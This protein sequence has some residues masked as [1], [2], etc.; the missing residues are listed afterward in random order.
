VPEKTFSRIPSKEEVQEVIESCLLQGKLNE[1]TTYL[2]TTVAN[3]V[4]GGKFDF[5]PSPTNVLQEFYTRQ[6]LIF[7]FFQLIDRY[8]QVTRTQAEIE[9]TIFLSGSSMIDSIYYLLDYQVVDVNTPHPNPSYGQQTVL[10]L[11]IGYQDEI[12]GRHLIQRNA[13]I[14]QLDKN[15]Q[16]P[17]S[18][19]LQ[20]LPKPIVYSEK[21]PFIN[22]LVDEFEASGKE[23]ELLFG[24]SESVE[25][26]EEEEEEE[27]SSEE[28]LRYQY[29]S[30]FILAGYAVKAKELIQQEVMT[31]SAIQATELITRCQGNFDSMVDAVG[32]F[33][34]LVS[35]GANI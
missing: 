28:I 23:D 32:A 24:T 31:I 11:A 14:F 25:E 22:W 12:L 21:S 18:L 5:D 20:V 17:F 26:E 35:L 15:S 19:S 6:E 10:H 9:M 34:L 2:T 16:S 3:E 1:L 29:V 13:N 7:L 30:Y 4:L 33:E 27:E 8:F